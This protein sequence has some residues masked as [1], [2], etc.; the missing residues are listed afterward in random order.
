MKTNEPKTDSRPLAE[1]ITQSTLETQINHLRLSPQ[2]TPTVQIYDAGKQNVAAFVYEA[3]GQL[4]TEA[5]NVTHETGRT[6]RQLAEDVAELRAALTTATEALAFVRTD[7]S[8]ECEATVTDAIDA[9]RA[10]LAKTDSCKPQTCA[11]APCDRCRGMGWV[12]SMT[13][14]DTDPCPKCQLP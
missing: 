9:A 13:A 1:R 14:A 7:V 11:T 8:P 5:S 2:G 6:P 3:D 10:I 4:F 12:P